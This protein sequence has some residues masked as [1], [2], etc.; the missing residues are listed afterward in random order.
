MMKFNTVIASFAFAGILSFPTLAEENISNTTLLGNDALIE[1]S[2]L[3]SHSE[4]S[5][6]ASSP[7]CENRGA[8][9]ACIDANEIV[10]LSFDARIDY[11]RDWVGSKNIKD[12]SGFEG[13]YI[14]MRLDGTI[15]PGLT[16][17]WRQRFNKYSSDSNFFDATDWLFVNYDYRDWSFNAG[18]EVV[19]IGGWEYDRAPINLYGC[20][21]FWNNVPCYALGVYAGYAVSPSDKLK[22]QITQSPFYTPEDRD[23]Y[24]YNL[25]WEGNH[26]IYKSLWSVNMM[27]YQRGKYIS[28]ISLGNKF[29]VDNFSL[30]LDLMNRANSHQTYFFKDCSLIAELSYKPTKHWN[31]F[32]K[33][34]YDVNKSGNHSDYCVED[35]TELNMIGAGVEFY[36]LRKK[37]TSLRLHANCFYAW[38]KNANP[39]NVMQNKTTLLDFG[40]TWYMNLI[41]VKR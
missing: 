8:N 24:S 33:Y 6:N 11:Q 15:L 41:K 36:P 32:A 29:D 26:G 10:N 5:D 4:I 16:Y 18:K 13:K 28:Y 30:E 7:S 2:N 38:G 1:V 21:V 20:S 14:N 34:T 19:L 22:F 27:E 9:P 12:N 23:L 35:G 3:T 37:I 40:V 25:F 31:I 39:G 17:S